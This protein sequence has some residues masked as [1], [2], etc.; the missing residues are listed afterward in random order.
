MTRPATLFPGR[1]AL[2]RLV[3]GVDG[4]TIAAWIS[5][6][7]LDVQSLSAQARF[8]TRTPDRAFSAPQV[9]GGPDTGA[10]ALDRAPDGHAVL[11]LDRQL[12]ASS[13]AVPEAAVRVPGG[14]LGPPQPL[15][16]AQFIPTPFGPAAAIDDRGTATVAWASGAQ[17]AGLPVTPAGVFAARGDAGAAFGP[18]QQLTADARTANQQH[19]VTAATGTRALVAWTTPDGAFVAT[20]TG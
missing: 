8:A 19:P 4:E 18:P 7:G 1:V 13:N 9:V 20:A 10:L 11:A 17:P 12:P 5:A 6:P 14:A 2:P 3:T 15:A 16:G